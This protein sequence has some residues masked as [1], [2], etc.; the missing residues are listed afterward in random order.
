MAWCLSPC[1]CSSV[2]QVWTR[3]PPRCTGRRQIGRAFPDPVRDSH[4]L[5]HNKRT[6]VM[7]SP[8]SPCP[9]PPRPPRSDVAEPRVPLATTSFFPF[10]PFPSPWP[11]QSLTGRSFCFTCLWKPALAPCLGRAGP[12]P[13][14]P[15]QNFAPSL[16]QTFFS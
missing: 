1:S 7:F 15:P 12:R 3:G 16:F 9:F 14:F 5:L 8:R 11:F 2:C 4:R 13:A 6:S 10:S